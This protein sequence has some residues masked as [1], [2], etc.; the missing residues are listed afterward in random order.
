MNFYEEI[1]KISKEKH[2]EKLTQGTEKFISLLKEAIRT[3]ANKGHFYIKCFN[4]T[5]LEYCSYEVSLYFQQLGFIVDNKAMKDGI[6]VWTIYWGRR[7]G[8]NENY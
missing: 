2:D 3:A 6:I 5:E 8:N 7:R 1:V 4:T